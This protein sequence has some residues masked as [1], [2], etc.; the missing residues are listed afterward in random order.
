MKAKKYIKRAVLFLLLLVLAAGFTVGG[1][2]VWNQY[3][4]KKRLAQKP[5]FTEKKISYGEMV[6]MV[7]AFHCECSPGFPWDMKEEDRPDYSHYT[8]EAT[9]DTEIAVTVLNYILFEDR[10]ERYRKAAELAKQ[11]GISDIY[12]YRAS[13]DIKAA[14]LAKQYGFSAENPITVDWVMENPEEAVEIMHVSADGGSDFCDKDYIYSMYKKITGKQVETEDESES[15]ESESDVSSNQI[16]EE[17]NWTDS[18]DYNS[19]L[20]VR[21]MAQNMA[22]LMNSYLFEEPDES[23]RKAIE[24]AE[25]YGVSAENPITAD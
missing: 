23:D 7:D 18:D 8:L 12:E 9:E 17:E 13:W 6:Y 19:M 4:E 10:G 22:T 21:A 25:Q 2:H 20:L 24:L 3:Q 16:Q 5:Y 1:R 14:E 15:D 11:Y